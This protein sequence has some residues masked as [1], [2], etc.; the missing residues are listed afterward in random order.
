MPRKAKKYIHP[1]P[2]LSLIDHLIYWTLFLFLIGSFL[3]VVFFP[4]YTRNTAAYTDPLVVANQ[5]TLSILWMFVPS[6]T[7]FSVGVYYF[8]IPYIKRIPIF[9]RR[10]F[11]YGPP[12]WPRVYPLFMKNKPKIRVSQY[13]R[14]KKKTIACWAAGLVL[15][16][17]LTF[18]LCFFGRE[19]LRSDG[20]ITQYGV[21]NQQT[22]G[23]SSEDITSVVIQTGKK[24]SGY[25]IGIELT[26][27]TGKTYLFRNNTFRQTFGGD[28][29]QVIK[30]MLEIKSQ[31][32]P[33]IISY[34]GTHRLGLVAWDYGLDKDSA[35]LL[36]QLFDMEQ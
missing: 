32:D 12:A 9:G 1:M 18:P 20:S 31:Y 2:K 26:T 27:K 19:C 30:T 17:L 24:R 36:Y 28:L 10:N 23:F 25:T 11:Q 8:I 4:E 21:F 33:Q 34:K 7:W 6:C 22:Y 14:N 16:G 3:F 5:E 15:L 35:A 13:D 29:P